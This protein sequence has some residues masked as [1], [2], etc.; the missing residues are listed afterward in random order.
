MEKEKECCKG[1]MRWGRDGE[2]EEREGW[3][4]R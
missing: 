1:R 4:S 3:M 2:E